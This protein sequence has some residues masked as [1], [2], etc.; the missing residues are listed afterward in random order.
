MPQRV[1]PDWLA[2]PGAA[3]DLADDPGSTVPI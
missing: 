1:R 2:D 3:S